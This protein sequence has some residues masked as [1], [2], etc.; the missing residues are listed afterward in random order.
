[1]T[2]VLAIAVTIVAHVFGWGK[3]PDAN[4]LI[5]TLSNK[6]YL[7]HRYLNQQKTS[8]F[9]DLFI[10]CSFLDEQHGARAMFKPIGLN[11][12]NTLHTI[13]NIYKHQTAQHQ[14]HMSRRFNQ[15]DASI[16]WFCLPSSPFQLNEM[17]S[18][19]NKQL[20]YQEIPYLQ[21]SQQFMCEL[22]YVFVCVWERKR[23]SV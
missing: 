9:S 1:M 10:L 16:V 20:L 15:Y 21:Q 7:R 23:E 12:M 8:F 11:N 6:L 4:H 22:L 18:I 14:T 3:Y 2:T 5:A 17:F 19:P 13:H